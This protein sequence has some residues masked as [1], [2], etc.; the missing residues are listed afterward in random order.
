MNI[1]F[2]G[3]SYTHCN[4]LPLMIQNL[5]AAAPDPVRISVEHVSP[6]G[7]NFKQHSENPDSLNAIAASGR[8]VVVLQNHSL[9]AVEDRERM[10]TY[11]AL[12]A[13][14]IREAGAEP[15][16]YMTWARQHI[17]D[18]IETI[19]DGYVTLGSN[20]GAKV[21]PVGLAWKAALEQDPSLNFYTE[22]QSH[23]T[24]LGSYLAACVLFGVLLE[25]SPENLSRSITLNGEPIIELE[26]SKARFLQTI[27]AGTIDSFRQRRGD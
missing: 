17:P 10:L 14:R 4:Q 26:N 24:A 11:G 5:A 23:P 19:R 13:E 25:R 12:L 1:L 9:G 16:L 2:I 27:A 7:W 3:N 15:L 8:D 20:I 6:G 22:D 21:A 18:M